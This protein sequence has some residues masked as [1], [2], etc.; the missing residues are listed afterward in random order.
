MNL[1]HSL[2]RILQ[3]I[4]AEQEPGYAQDTLP[5][6]YWPSSGNLR[7]EKLSASYTEVLLSRSREIRI[8][9]LLAG[10][11]RCSTRSII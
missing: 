1:L 3:Y 7:V 10:S 5:P 8:S 11:L 4:R 6:A 9:D 2:E